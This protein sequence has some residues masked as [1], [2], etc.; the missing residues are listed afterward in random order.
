MEKEKEK[1][2]EI[3]LESQVSYILLPGVSSK[4]NELIKGN[5]SPN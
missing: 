3:V 5:L 1:E 4:S 2:G